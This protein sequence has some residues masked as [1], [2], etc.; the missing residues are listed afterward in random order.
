MKGIIQIRNSLYNSWTSKTTS[1]S[2]DQGILF[3]AC[4]ILDNYVFF[5]AKKCNFAR[6]CFKQITIKKLVY[7]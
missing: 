5:V 6:L 2:G 7:G 4:F 1:E 3:L